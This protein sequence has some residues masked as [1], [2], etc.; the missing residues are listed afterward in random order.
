MCLV[1]AVIALS[2]LQVGNLCLM[3]QLMLVSQHMSV[4]PLQ[5][6]D[7]LSS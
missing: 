6:Y 1:V 3:V 7:L 2:D 5:G 4:R